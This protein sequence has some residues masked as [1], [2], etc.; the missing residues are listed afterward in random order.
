MSLSGGMDSEIYGDSRNRFRGYDTSIA[1]GDEAEYE[2]SYITTLFIRFIN[3]F[4]FI[5]G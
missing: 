1:A 3:D 2:V 5:S 4:L